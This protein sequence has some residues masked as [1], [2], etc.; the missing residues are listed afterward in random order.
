[1]TLKDLPVGT[2]IYYSGD[3]ANAEA[4][5][6][7][8]KT[9]S[10]QFGERLEVAFDNGKTK[11]LSPVYFS[12]EYTGEGDTRF[13]TEKAYRE[14]REKILAQFFTGANRLVSA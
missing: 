7:V 4:F 11:I 14:Y 10:T 5:G 6:T 9:Y 2:R 1:M 8:T 3:M 12:P 13:V